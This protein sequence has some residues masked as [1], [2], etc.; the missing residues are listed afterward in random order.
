MSEKLGYGPYSCEITVEE[1][2]T[3]T[4]IVAYEKDIGEAYSLIEEK[5]KDG[6]LDMDDSVFEKEIIS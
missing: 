2:R 4:F 3:K 1:K 5:I 6:T